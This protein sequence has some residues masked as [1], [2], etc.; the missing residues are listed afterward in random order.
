MSHQ[1]SFGA[2]MQH[3]QQS[4]TNELPPQAS[5]SSIDMSGTS[6]PSQSQS[7]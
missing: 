5:R 3:Q 2:H 7:H 6:G 4:L 1:S